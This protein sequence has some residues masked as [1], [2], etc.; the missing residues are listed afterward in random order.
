MNAWTTTASRVQWIRRA[1][2]AAMLVVVAVLLELRPLTADAIPTEDARRPTVVLVHGAWADGSSWNRVVKHLQEAGYSVV[3]PPNPL[4]GLSSDAAYLSTYLE[5][6]H[7]PIVLVGHSYGGAVISNVASGSADVRALVYV[8]AFIP[9]RGD[10]I[11]HLAGAVPGSCLAGDGDPTQVFDFVSYPGAPSGD[12]DLYVKR[13]ANGPYPGFH[14]CFANDLPAWKA[15]VLASTQRPITL[16]ALA[17]P[18]GVPAWKTLPSWAVV[19][20]IDNVI[21]EQGQLFMAERA[22]SRIT[23]LK[24][25]HLSMISRPGAVADVI[26]RADRRTR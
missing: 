19:G 25:S 22:G 11:L 18:S 12:F 10:S 26:V 9:K 8:D 4:R 15:S 23:R 3:A 13:A 5:T 16:S 21:P 20:T 2:L 14:A 1:S 17:E 6:I 7:G 24:A